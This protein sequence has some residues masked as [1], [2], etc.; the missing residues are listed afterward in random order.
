M[1]YTIYNDIIIY[2]A[3]SDPIWLCTIQALVSQISRLVLRFWFMRTNRR[4]SALRH[5]GSVRCEQHE[6][7]SLFLSLSRSSI[8]WPEYH[9][10]SPPK[11]KHCAQDHF[12]SS[13]FHWFLFTLILPHFSS[14]PS[15]LSFRL[16]TPLI[17]FN[18]LHFLGGM[19][20][21]TD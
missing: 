19:Y 21:A 18:W 12:S 10:M 5:I 6:L 11:R 8:R 16:F 4:H 1:P 15:V 3:S 7:S 13:W 9:T 2:L 14:Y 17:C 20:S